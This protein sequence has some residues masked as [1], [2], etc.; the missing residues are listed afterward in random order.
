[1]RETELQLIERYRRAAAQH[2][3]STSEG[4]V[5]ETNKAADEIAR[6]Y[7]ELR[8]RGLAAQQLLLPL[9]EDDDPGVR[10]WA[11]AHALEFAQEKGVPVLEAEARYSDDL[12]RFGAEMTLR[13]WRKGTLKFP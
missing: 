5:R 9:L 6:V 1:M 10:G 12:H 2:Y 4:V 13:E 11:A 7:R 8:Q 3:R